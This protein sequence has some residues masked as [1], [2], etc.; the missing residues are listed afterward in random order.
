MVH[1]TRLPLFRIRC[2]LSSESIAWFVQCKC[3]TS[4][5]RNSGNL[6]MSLPKRAVST[7]NS[8]SREKP[9]RQNMSKRSNANFTFRHSVGLRF[10]TSVRSAGKLRSRHSKVASTP[11]LRKAL[12][13]RRAAMA[14]PPVWSEVL[15]R[16]TF[17]V[18]GL[19]V[20]KGK[21]SASPVCM[22][23]FKNILR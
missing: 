18:N 20:E 16:S 9:L 8:P 17:M 1:T 14:A 13:R 15:M 22:P 4:A 2:K 23:V 10:T 3:T 6:V 7:A 19:A 12:S 21:A 5:S 11:A